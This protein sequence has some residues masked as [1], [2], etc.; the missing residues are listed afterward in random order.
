MTINEAQD[1]I[2]EEFSL[3]DDW[4][5]KYEYII[6]IGKKLPPLDEKHK[7]E[8]NII[9]GCQSRVWLQPELKGHRVVFESDSDAV[10]VKGLAGLLIRVLSGHTP[11]EIA[12]ADVYFIDRIGM[13]QHL[14][15]TRANGLFSM[16]KQMKMYALAYSTMS[17]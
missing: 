16:L 7:T 9:K 3:F 2:I 11:E 13:A 17:K 15:Q 8:E 12:K 1:E 5:G 4:E 6:D 14:A 10:I